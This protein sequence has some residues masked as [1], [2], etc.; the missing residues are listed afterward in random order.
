MGASPALSVSVCVERVVPD[1]L[2]PPGLVGY[3]HQLLPILLLRLGPGGG[4]E[5]DRWIDRLMDT[6]IG[7]KRDR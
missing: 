1:L 2:K 3:Q 7:R 4:E 6:E 5:V